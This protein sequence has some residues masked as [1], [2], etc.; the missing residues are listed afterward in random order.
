MKV[1][2]NKYEIPN[3]CNNCGAIA[4]GV[5]CHYC[6]I[7]ANRALEVDPEKRHDNCPIQPINAEFL[8]EQELDAFYDDV[9][10]AIDGED[11]E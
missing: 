7:S 6:W 5:F 2:M 9:L 10:D 3:N 4:T 8:E 1:Y 11:E